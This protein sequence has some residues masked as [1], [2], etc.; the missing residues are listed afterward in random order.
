MALIWPK[1]GHRV[2]FLLQFVS[3]HA[4]SC[5]FALSIVALL[6]IT[7]LVH[8]PGIARYD[9]MFVLCILIQG[10]LLLTK[11]ETWK[12]AGVVALFHVLGLAME[13]VK[14]RAGSWSYPEPS[15]LQI[16]GVP[17]Y[18]G[19]MYGSVASFMC[20]AW[21]RLNLRA[22]HWPSS[23]SAFVTAMLVYCQFFIH[24]WSLWLRLAMLVGLV[25]LFVRSKVLYSIDGQRYWLP[26]PVAF[27]LIGLMIYGA[28]NVGTYLGGW[29]YGYQVHGW[30]PVHIGKLLAWILLMAVSLIIVAEYKRTLRQLEPESAM[31]PAVATD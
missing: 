28:E 22:E 8:F 16:Q 6:G 5:G 4:V 18:A 24:G 23:F 30:Q 31:I 21:R 29:Q 14:V 1:P 2:R 26:M 27:G 17:L 13:T 10:I 12:D 9:L 7:K 11:L 15:L 25:A 19:F 3:Q 20:L